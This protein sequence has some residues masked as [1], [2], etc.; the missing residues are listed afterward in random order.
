MDMEAR[1]MNDQILTEKCLGFR[2]R[3]DAMASHWRSYSEL[4]NLAVVEMELFSRIWVKSRVEP[5]DC[6]SK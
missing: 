3:V 1:V 6:D 4:Q 5:N 2:F